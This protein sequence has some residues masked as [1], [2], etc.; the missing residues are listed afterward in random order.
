M[1]DLTES[2]VA[3]RVPSLV[4]RP[5]RVLSRRDPIVVGP[6]TSLAVCLDAI[7]RGGIGD[8]VLV[9]DEGGRLLGVLAERDVFGRL[10]DGSFDLAAP[11]ETLMTRDPKR[12]RLDASIR[13][14]M[15]LMATGRYRN[16][17]LVADDG[18]AVGIVR[19]TDVLRYLAEAFPEELLNLPPRPHQ[20]LKEQAGA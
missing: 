12:L 9:V 3:Q 17:P 10:T 15:T 7:R 20:L 18:R 6:G 14:A 13:D 2:A 4:D 8:S 16:V 1:T 11:V 5:I 19:Q